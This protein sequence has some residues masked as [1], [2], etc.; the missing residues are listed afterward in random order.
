MWTVWNHLYGE[1]TICTLPQQGL[2]ELSSLADISVRSGLGAAAEGSVCPW[3]PGGA[4][5][6]GLMDRQ[7]MLIK[8][9]HVSEGG[10][11]RAARTVCARSRCSR[12]VKGGGD[13]LAGAANQGIAI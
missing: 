12:E 11:E 13:G 3:G 1:R 7:E 9:L 4:T 10:E 8:R 5:W 2:E 6:A